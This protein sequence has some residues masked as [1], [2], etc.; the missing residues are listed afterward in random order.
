V[1]SLADLKLAPF[2]LLATEGVVHSDK[3]H[4]WH[5]TTLGRLCA[6]DPGLLL[7]TPYKV[8]D[9]GDEASQKE[10][11][12]WWEE[13]T[14]S[15]GEGM[16]VK[17]LQFVT[18]SRRGLVQ[19]PVKC[20]DR[21]YGHIIYGPAYTAPQLLERLRSRS[22]GRGGRWRCEFALGM[23]AFNGSWNGSR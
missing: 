21:E 16:V 7:A 20:R 12:D 13:L 6:A 11:I 3:D 15:G 19:T 1:R 9:L 17:P 5:M 8:V 4:V 10:G 18:K 23:E 22:R 14:A 2:H